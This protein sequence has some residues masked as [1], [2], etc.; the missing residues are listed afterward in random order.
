MSE[1]DL[2][3]VY[4]KHKIL[5]D[6]E[7]KVVKG[8]AIDSSLD[9]LGYEIE[10]NPD[11]DGKGIDLRAKHN[12]NIGVEVERG[13]WVGDFW[14]DDYY[15]NL[16]A[17]GFQTV[18]MPKRKE[19]YYLPYYHVGKGKNKILVDNREKQ[20]K[21]IFERW[22]W[23]GSQVILVFADVVRNPEKLQRSVFVPNNNEEKKPE[24]W[25]SFKREDVVT[26]NKQSYDKFVR[27]TESGGKYVDL[28]P[29]ERRKQLMEV[30]EDKARIQS[31]KAV[32]NLKRVREVM[33]EAR[34][35][36]KI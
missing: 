6:Y 24:K 4:E 34:K 21:V 11:N 35:N 19:K 3:W 25:L 8:Y 12:H 26:M 32:K 5:A 33:A 31:E 9:L 22:N 7:D 10:I 28:T 1:L 13:H 29:M 15:S 30:A 16:S 20:D 36:G 23:D 17:L 14:E 18:N 2:N 27:D